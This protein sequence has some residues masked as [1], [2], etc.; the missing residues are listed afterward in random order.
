MS[1]E[2]N[3]SICF[4]EVNLIFSLS[5]NDLI[6]FRRKFNFVHPDLIVFYRYIFEEVTNAHWNFSKF[7]EA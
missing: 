3:K 5:I 6:I 4:S 7:F 2:K 1:D